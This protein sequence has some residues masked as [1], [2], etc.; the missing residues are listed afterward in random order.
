MVRANGI[1]SKNKAEL[2]TTPNCKEQTSS[3]AGD[4]HTNQSALV[5]V[6]GD[7]ADNNHGESLF[8][9]GMK[10]YIAKVLHDYDAQ[11]ND[12]LSL[13]KGI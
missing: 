1:F 11:D 4:L 5:A 7:N 6:D 10:P 12:E 3:V 13:K 2:L 8:T 9:G